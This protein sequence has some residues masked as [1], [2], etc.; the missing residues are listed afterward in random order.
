M[1]HE[2]QGNYIKKIHYYKD[3]LPN[4]TFKFKH[5]KDAYRK[6]SK[7]W[8]NCRFK[9]LLM[10]VSFRAIIENFMDEKPLYITR[11]LFETSYCLAKRLTPKTGEVI[12]TDWNS[13]V[14]G[15]W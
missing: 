11:S 12:I 10:E 6:I 4:Q 3:Y 8:N 7:I 14:N 9:C 2:L 1:Q 13:I 15:E 5:L